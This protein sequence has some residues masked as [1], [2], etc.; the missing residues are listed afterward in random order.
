[1][2][3]IQYARSIAHWVKRNFEHLSAHN[4]MM[5]QEW[6]LEDFWTRQL[7]RNLEDAQA[8]R[9]YRFFL[10]LR[11][12]P[13][14]AH[15]HAKWIG[16]ASLSLIQAPPLASAQL[17]MA[18]DEGLSNRGFGKEAAAGL[19]KFGFQQLGLNRI[20]IWVD[21]KNRPSAHAAEAMGFS[22]EGVVRGALYE[23]DPMTGQYNSR[24]Q[25]QYSFLS[26]DAI[27]EYTAS[28]P[29]KSVDP[30]AWG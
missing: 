14:S 26:R 9:A 5:H 18:I 13:R 6:C 30:R 10:I 21:P 4:K 20:W 1:M 22:F 25:L 24:D 16:N 8:G 11:D 19:M 15:V 27:Y 23:L 2:P 28:N 7:K 3:E 12:E 29:H 17:G